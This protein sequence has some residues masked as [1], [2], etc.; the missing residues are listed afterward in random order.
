MCTTTMMM[1][2]CRSSDK[3]K[4]AE[5]LKGQQ[6]EGEKAMRERGGTNSTSLS[7]MMPGTLNVSNSVSQLFLG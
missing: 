7:I 1:V 4:K 5:K 6:E 3:A 2:G